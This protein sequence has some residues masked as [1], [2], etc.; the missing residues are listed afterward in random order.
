[1]FCGYSADVLKKLGIRIPISAD[2]VQKLAATTRYSGD[3]IRR[4]LGFTPRIT[5]EEGIAAAVEGFRREPS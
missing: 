4:E 5:L 3:L 1:M 2:Q